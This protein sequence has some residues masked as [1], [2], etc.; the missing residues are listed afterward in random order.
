[1]SKSKRRNDKYSDEHKDMKHRQYFK[2]HK[3]EQ[4]NNKWMNKAIKTKDLTTLIHY[5][6]DDY[7]NL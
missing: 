6:E 7:A 4:R 3:S 2:K 5:T 1:M